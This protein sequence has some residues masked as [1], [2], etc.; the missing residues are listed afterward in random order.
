MHPITMIKMAA[1]TTLAKKKK[2]NKIK[3]RGR[4]FMNLHKCYI[5][6]HKK[7]KVFYEDHI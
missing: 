4:K 5:Q 1:A 3:A 7:A 2:K 6:D